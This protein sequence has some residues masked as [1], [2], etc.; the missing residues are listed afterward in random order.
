MIKGPE[1]ITRYCSSSVVEAFSS[2]DF[3]STEIKVI[4]RS[5]CYQT[6]KTIISNLII[7]LNPCFNIILSVSE[8]SFGVGDHD[9]SAYT[10]F[11]KDSPTPVRN[12]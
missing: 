2:S 8:E 12:L 6:N 9:H 7:C 11:S 1:L 3:V 4:Q 10:C 5:H